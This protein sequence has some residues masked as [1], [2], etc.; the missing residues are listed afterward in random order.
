VGGADGGRAGAPLLLDALDGADRPRGTA[1]T[2]R[3]RATP[4]IAVLRMTF[5]ANR[6]L[7]VLIVARPTARLTF[8]IVP[9]AARMACC[10]TV[11]FAPA[12]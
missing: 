6:L 12:R 9:P 7:V 10:A 4:S 3:L 5:A 8:S 11:A 2:A 1:A